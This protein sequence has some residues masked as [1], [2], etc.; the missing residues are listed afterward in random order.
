MVKGREKDKI[1]GARA[2]DHLGDT[3]MLSFGNIWL[4]LFSS[5]MVV[6]GR[7]QKN[8]KNLVKT[9]PK[10]ERT[11]REKIKKL[12]VIKGKEKKQ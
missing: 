9:H 6:K 5:P 3:V 7:S 2:S 8:K 4:D 12:L 11:K 10:G 1:C